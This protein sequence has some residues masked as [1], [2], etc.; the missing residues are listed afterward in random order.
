MK[1]GRILTQLTAPKTV[2]VP[3]SPFLIQ[4]FHKS[5]LVGQQKMAGTLLPSHRPVRPVPT[6]PL[7]CYTPIINRKKGWRKNRH[8]NIKQINTK[9]FKSHLA[10]G[11]QSRNY[12]A[13][14]VE[15]PPLINYLSL[16]L[17]RIISGA[18]YSGVPH[19]VQVR[20]FTRLAKPKSVTWNQNR[21]SNINC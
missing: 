17:L 10:T 14:P 9:V 12:T 2:N 8:H 13:A 18:R 19:S 21:R 1:Y 5:E 7:L 4:S 3:D 15:F 6:S 20:P 16:T 11:I